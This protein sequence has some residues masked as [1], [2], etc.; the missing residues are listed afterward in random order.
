MICAE[1]TISGVPVTPKKVSPKRDAKH[2]TVSAECE[3]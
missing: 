1:K 2:F 3:R